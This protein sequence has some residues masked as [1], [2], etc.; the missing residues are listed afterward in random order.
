MIIVS[1]VIGLPI[2]EERCVCCSFLLSFLAILRVFD[3]GLDKNS[4]EQF[5]ALRGSQ[6]VKRYLTD[7]GSHRT[8]GFVVKRIF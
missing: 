4:L 2:I 3:P 7:T 6:S 1:A 8:D 5:P